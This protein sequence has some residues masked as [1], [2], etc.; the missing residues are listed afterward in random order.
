MQTKFSAGV[1][2]TVALAVCSVQAAAQN[3]TS[4]VPPPTPVP[5]PAPAPASTSAYVIGPDDV[6]EISFWRD[7]DMSAEVVVR[8]D[9]K[10]TLPLLGEVEAGGLNPGQLI[11]R[12]VTLAR[13]FVEAPSA[14][15]VVKEINSRKVYITGSVAK[16]GPYALTSQM[17]VLQL[18][19]MAGGLT[20]WAK[21]GDILIIR[22][23]PKPGAHKF[24]Y[25]ALIRH[26]TLSQNIRLEPGDTIV[27]P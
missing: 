16:P 2:V 15:V 11:E 18:I 19:A 23:G 3:G 1:L 13:R 5:A 8:P 12:V 9:G 24:S 17:T 7:K 6:L 26:R 22:A 10:I 27:V 21:K 4:A 25:E 14:T 20:E